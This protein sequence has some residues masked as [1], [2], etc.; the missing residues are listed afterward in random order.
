MQ[1]L[2]G[3]NDVERIVGRI[4]GVCIAGPEPDVR[5][6]H[7]FRVLLGRVDHVG[8]RVDTDDLARRDA[9]R[10]VDR[11]GAW[12]AAEIEQ[13]L[14]RPQPVEQVSSRVVGGARGMTTHHRWMMP[15]GVHVAAHASRLPHQRRHRGG[16][17]GGY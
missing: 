16:E 8:G 2:M 7:R 5:T 10:E 1:H 4:D 15:V 17:T 3:V 14:A 12:A 9:S 13:P 11:D 6:A